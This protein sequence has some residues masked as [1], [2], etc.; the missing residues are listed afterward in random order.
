MNLMRVK[1][2]LSLNRQCVCVVLMKETIAYTT[3]DPFG[4]NRAVNGTC[5]MFVRLS[6]CLANSHGQFTHRPA[7]SRTTLTDGRAVFIPHA[8]FSAPEVAVQG[9]SECQEV[10]LT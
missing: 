1:N 5:R 8:P 3:V 4:S 10:A 2:L 7:Q 9:L 6:G